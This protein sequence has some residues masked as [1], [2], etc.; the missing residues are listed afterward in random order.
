ML[1]YIARVHFKWEF[2]R[3]GDYFWKNYATVIYA[4]DTMQNAL[5]SDQ[6]L[7]NDYRVFADRVQ[8]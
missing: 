7:K 3:I 5:E 6:Q 2:M 8:Q 1:M 4:V